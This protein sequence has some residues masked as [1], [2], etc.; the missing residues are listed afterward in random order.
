MLVRTGME[1]AQLQKALAQHALG[2]NIRA[3][4]MCW[5]VLRGKVAT[6]V[7]TGKGPAQPPKALARLV[8]V[9]NIQLLPMYWPV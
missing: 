3:L 9:T 2:E 6:L 7:L 4:P 8:Q 1:Q 5:L